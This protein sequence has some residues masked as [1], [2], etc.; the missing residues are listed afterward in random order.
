MGSGKRFQAPLVQ[1]ASVVKT[2]EYTETLSMFFLTMQ[3][4]PTNKPP[5][6]TAQGGVTPSTFTPAMLPDYAQT[7]NVEGDS[8]SG[9]GVRGT[10]NSGIGVVGTSSTDDGVQGRSQKGAGVHGVGPT[11]GKF[12]GNVV[13]SGDITSGPANINGQA[14]VGGSLT[15]TGDINAGGNV[16]V[17]GDVTFSGGDCAE[18]ID[19]SA[20]VEPGNVVVIDGTGR[21]SRCCEAYDKRV[22]GVVSGA[23]TL[24]PAIILGKNPDAE[25]RALLAISGRVFCRVDADFGPIEIGDLLTSSSTPGHAMRAD[26]ER[27]VGRVIGKSLGRIESGRGLI[28]ILVSL[29]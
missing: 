20:G 19:A 16:N 8:D 12:D 21:L 2:H 28:P 4:M 9:V 18:E 5:P 13:V 27:S 7:A 1:D 25:S 11:A 23:G 22:V 6:P 17:T 10:S 3:D 26:P 15:T 14:M 29:L 24:K